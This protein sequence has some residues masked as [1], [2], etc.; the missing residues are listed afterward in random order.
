MSWSTV[1]Y[2]SELSDREWALLEPELPAAKPGGRP[3]SVDLRVILNGIFYVLR[4][5]WERVGEVRGDETLPA[6][7]RF[8]ATGSAS[9]IS[10]ARPIQ[11]PGNVFRERDDSHLRMLFDSARSRS[12]VPRTVASSKLLR[13]AS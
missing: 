4:S 7:Q 9:H 1:P 6:R 8:A 12:R 11:P 13:C 10:V 5:G 2:P 3:R